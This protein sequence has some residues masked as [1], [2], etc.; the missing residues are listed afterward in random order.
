[1]LDDALRSA[2]ALTR[3][4]LDGVPL[5]LDAAAL[6]VDRIGA[7][8]GPSLQDQA[9]AAAS[10]IAA[11]RARAG[12]RHGVVACYAIATLVADAEDGLEP[13]CH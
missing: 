6:M 5:D 4:I 2:L 8:G 10:A 12:T 9:R 1:M 11:A 13:R 3:A 7:L